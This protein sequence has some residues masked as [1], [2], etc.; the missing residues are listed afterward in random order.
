LWFCFASQVAIVLWTSIGAANSSS[1]FAAEITSS[2]AFKVTAPPVEMKLDSFYKKYV[3]AN[4]YPIVSSEKVADHAL[5]EAAYLVDLLLHQRPDVREAMI[6]SG[7]RMTVIAHNEFTTD[8]PEHRHL[9]PKDYWDRRARGTGGSKDD[10]VCTCGE[11]NLLAY[12]GDPYAAEC[13]LIH[14]F[15]HN[16]HL[17]GLN[18]IDPSFDDRVKKTFENAIAQ[19]LW[20]RAYASTN[21]HEYFAEGVQSWFDN[22]RPPDHDH[23]H[24]DTRKELKEYDPGLAALCHEVFGE[25]E[26][27]YTKPTTRLRGH[28][29]D[30]D[31]SQ[32]PTFRWPER[33]VKIGDEIRFNAIKKRSSH[34]GY[35][36]RIIEG[37]PVIIHEQLLRDEQPVTERAVELVQAQLKE[38][39]RVVPAKAVARL[40]QVPLWFSPEYPETAPRAEY[41]PDANWLRAN[42]RHPEMAKAVEFSNTRILEREVKR[43][44]LLTLHELSHAYHDQVLSFDNAEIKAV[45]QRIVDGK[46]YECVERTYGDPSRPNTFGK[47]MRCRA[48]E[49]TSPKPPKRSLARTIFIRSIAPNWPATIRRCSNFCRD[50]GES[51]NNKEGRQHDAQPSGHCRLHSL[52]F[53]VKLASGSCCVLAPRYFNQNCQHV[54]PETTHTAS[55]DYV[56]RF[57]DGAQRRLDGLL[58][59]FVGPIERMERADDRYG[60]LRADLGGIRVLFV[61]DSQRSAAQSTASQLC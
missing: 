53:C 33:L 45:Y 55:A 39:V 47:R 9:K 13:I 20:K 46:C 57:D 37:W 22:N 19:G 44:P 48:T 8:I 58:D 27:T 1:S 50:C 41:H 12:R 60:G 59:R 61:F 35:E 7:S 24:V 2:P 52:T 56:E 18:N 51:R 49:N 15:A 14:E 21:H 10:P 40:R 25:T 5:L 32:A 30:Y 23:N 36:T 31:P 11:E 17:R 42:G 43:M 29:A 34:A 38:I 54:S 28:L 26:L 4:G 6:R 16:I 3:S